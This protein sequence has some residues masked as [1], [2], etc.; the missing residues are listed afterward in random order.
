VPG[1]L[2]PPGPIKGVFRHRQHFDM[3][4]AQFFDVGNQLIRQFPVGEKAGIGLLAYLYGIALL[5]RV[6][7][8]VVE[9]GANV[10]LIDRNRL[11]LRIAVAAALQPVVILPVCRSGQQ[12]QK[13]YRA[14]PAAESRRGQTLDTDAPLNF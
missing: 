4:V 11:L 14:A 6:A 5:G 10:Q 9:P 1:H 7:Y 12:L 3:G 13:P 2:V 8:A